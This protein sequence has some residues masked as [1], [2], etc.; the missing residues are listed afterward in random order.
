ME[1]IIKEEIDLDFSSDCHEEQSSVDV[2]QTVPAK[3]PLEMGNGEIRI[4][5]E[6]T[7][8]ANDSDLGIT[9]QISEETMFCAESEKEK[10]IL[11]NHGDDDIEVAAEEFIKQEVGVEN[12][13][14]EDVAEEEKPKPVIIAIKKRLRKRC[15]KFTKAGTSNDKK[16]GDDWRAKRQKMLESGMR[17]ADRVGNLCTFRCPK[18]QNSYKSS[19]SF[20]THCTRTLKTRCPLE[21][22]S[23]KWHEYLENVVSHKCKICS[24]LL[25]CDGET[26]KHH[27]KECHRMKTVREYAEKTKCTMDNCRGLKETA[28]A[29]L[30]K[31]A[32]VTTHVGNFCKF[33]C[34]KCGYISKSWL[35]MKNHLTKHKD[36]PAKRE[37]FKYISETTLHKCMVCKEKILNDRKFIAGH[38][39]KNHKTTVPQYIDKYNLEQVRWRRSKVNTIKVEVTETAFAG[40]QT[41]PPSG[42]KSLETER[43]DKSD[44]EDMERDVYGWDSDEGWVEE[45]TIKQ[46]VKESDVDESS[47]SQCKLEHLSED[48]LAEE[49]EEASST[50]QTRQETGS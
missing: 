31:S 16:V 24:K 36:V 4:K 18:C 6:I 50:V 43:L 42:D 10:S 2:N 7:E 40:D 23:Q 44:R 13:E 29:D 8:E 21:I 35:D 27:V 5:Q 22:D 41:V 48:D 26:I 9:T 12:V 37:W 39:R 46:E 45:T 47:F 25:L 38:L 3:A 30:S 19:A 17:S 14:E 20:K 34:D 1:V 32:N 49:E 15:G 28:F 11:P 33:T